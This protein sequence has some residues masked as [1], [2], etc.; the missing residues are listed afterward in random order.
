MLLRLCAGGSSNIMTREGEQKL[1]LGSCKSRRSSSKSIANG[2]GIHASLTF[3]LRAACRARH[4]HGRGTHAARQRRECMSSGE[5]R[6]SSRQATRC[7]IWDRCGH[8]RAPM[9]RIVQT[10]RGRR[11]VCHCMSHWGQSVHDSHPCTNDGLTDSE[12]CDSSCCPRGCT[13]EGPS[14][15]AENEPLEEGLI[16]TV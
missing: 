12:C 15:A 1:R 8:V 4:R 9:C 3:L 7:W 13:R 5:V 16:S 14:A 11:S 10:K 2:A 6:K